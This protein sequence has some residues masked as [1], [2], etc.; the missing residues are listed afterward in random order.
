MAQNRAI[1]QDDGNNDNKHLC[2]LPYLP[3]KYFYYFYFRNETE[4]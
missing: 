4:P 1:T 2:D 3:T